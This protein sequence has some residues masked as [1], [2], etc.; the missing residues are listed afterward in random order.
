MNNITISGIITDIHDVG[1][2]KTV[3]VEDGA[4]SFLKKEKVTVIY[5][6][7]VFNKR[8]I[9]L[10]EKY[11][12]PNKPVIISGE[13]QPDSNNG[14]F[15]ISASSVSFTPYV[16]KKDSPTQGSNKNDTIKPNDEITFEDDDVPF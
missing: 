6:C 4:Y 10:L 12:H 1:K 2:G 15:E 11:F 3:R 8:G 5:N 13:L 14:E 9:E 7:N 16:P